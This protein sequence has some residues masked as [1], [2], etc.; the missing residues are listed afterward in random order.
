M[1]GTLPVRFVPQRTD[2]LRTGRVPPSAG[3]V[4][5]CPAARPV[6]IQ[7]FVH[8]LPRQLVMCSP[9]EL[10]F[11]A[12]CLD[13]EPIPD[14]RLSVRTGYISNPFEAE[15][16]FRGEMIDW[17]QSAGKLSL[18]TYDHVVPIHDDGGQLTRLW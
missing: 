15:L 12:F 4:R 10:L 13:R 6:H 8:S 1:Q 3:S 18:I 2:G 7:S 11:S 5:A 14:D 17:W 9:E 16:F